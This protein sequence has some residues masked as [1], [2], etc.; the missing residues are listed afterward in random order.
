[1][2]NIYIVSNTNHELFN[3]FRCKTVYL[4][5]YTIIHFCRA[6]NQILL[7]KICSIATSW[8]IGTCNK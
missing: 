3:V 7:Q 5:I 4:E 8:K 2:F 6:L 1:M